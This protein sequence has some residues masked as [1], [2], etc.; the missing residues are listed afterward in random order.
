MKP[1]RQAHPV[2][3]VR[4]GVPDHLDRRASPD[5]DTPARRETEGYQEPEDHREKRVPRES[6]VLQPPEMCSG[7]SRDL[8]DLPVLEVGT[9]STDFRDLPDGTD[10]LETKAFLDSRATR[11]MLD[12]QACQAQEV[13]RDQ[14]E[15][16]EKQ[17]PWGFLAN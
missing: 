14:E 17:A 13:F 5:T 15:R 6:V 16:R 4:K 9:V 1:D 10:F 3:P 11:E 7:P 8:L 2:F 12:S